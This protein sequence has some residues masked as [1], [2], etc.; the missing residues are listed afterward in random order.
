MSGEIVLYDYWRSSA[1]YRVRIALNLKGLAY[2]SVPIDLACGEQSGADY[3]AR[4]PQGLIPALEIDGHLLT[5]SLAIIDYLDAT[6]AQPSIVSS[7]PLARSRDIA[8]A[9]VIAADIH[10]VQ[11]LRVMNRLKS[12]FGAV[13]GDAVAWNRHWIAQGFAALEADAPEDGLFGGRAPSLADICLVPQMANARRFETPLG[14]FPRL[15]R[16]DTALRAL[17]AF[18]AAAPD[19]VRPA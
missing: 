5:Q 10:P 12:Q 2:R 18:V 13:H 14:A 4:N 17:P 9:L 8:R 3:T 16:I 7:D 15:V 6:R 19:A 1:A 11:N